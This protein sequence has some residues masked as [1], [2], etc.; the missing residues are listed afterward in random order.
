M[1]TKFLVLALLS[2]TFAAAASNLRFLADAPIAHMNA[3]DTA[4]MADAI[5]QALSKN[6]DNEASNWK[7]QET[8]SKGT[9]IPLNTYDAYDTKCRKLKI[10]S[11]AGGESADS[12]F[13]FCITA[14][15]EWKVLK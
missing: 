2:A 10:H 5:Q 8:G 7:N 15:G 6:K 12:E 11:E 13:D 3:V 14:E 1:K 9:L 4:L